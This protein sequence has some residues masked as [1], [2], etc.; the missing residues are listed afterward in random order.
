MN[1]YMSITINGKD[2][3]CDF[4]ILQC[5]PHKLKETLMNLEIKHC[6]HNPTDIVN[7]IKYIKSET[8][9]GRH[10][11]LNSFHYLVNEHCDIIFYSV[12][13]AHTEEELKE[14]I[15]TNIPKYK[16]GD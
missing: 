9:P 12:F 1:Y 16:G 6:W 7:S 13:E 14:L 8:L 5:E 2:E 4:F 10:S 11:T 15:Y 3:E